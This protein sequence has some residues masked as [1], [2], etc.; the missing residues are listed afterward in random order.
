MKQ[1]DIVRVKQN[2]VVMEYDEGYRG[3]KGRINKIYAD[4]DLKV[5]LSDGYFLILHPDEVEIEAEYTVIG[6][7]FSTVE[8]EDALGYRSH[9]F[10]GSDGK[11][12]CLRCD[13][14]RCEHAK[15]VA[16]QKIEVAGPP[17]LSQN[18]IDDILTY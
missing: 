2:A 10:L 5:V 15:W 17:E 18:D 7:S 8:I 13:R 9:V 12:K 11:W 4:G 6:K 16:A 3:K 1:Y 14:Y